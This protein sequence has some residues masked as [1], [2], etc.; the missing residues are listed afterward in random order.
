MKYMKINNINLVLIE[1]LDEQERKE[2][3][4]MKEEQMNIKTKTTQY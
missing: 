1:S 2:A 4:T 3:G